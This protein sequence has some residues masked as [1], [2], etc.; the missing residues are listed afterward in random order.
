MRV[1]CV[2]CDETYSQKPHQA[3]KEGSFALCYMC[4]MEPPTDYLC[5]SKNSKGGKCKQIRMFNSQYCGVHRKDWR[6]N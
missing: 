4:R 5:I 1:E 3:A 6:R 2:N